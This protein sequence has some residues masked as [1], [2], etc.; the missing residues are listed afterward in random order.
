MDQF[1]VTATITNI[2]SYYVYNSQMNYVFTNM[3]TTSE[4]F[5]LYTYPGM[6]TNYTAPQKMNIELCGSQQ[7]YNKIRV[8]FNVPAQTSG[9]LVFY[10]VKS[11]NF[12][13]KYI[14]TGSKLIN[15]V[16]FNLWDK[17]LDAL[18]LMIGQGD[19]YYELSTRCL[20]TSAVCKFGI[21]TN[22]ISDCLVCKQEYELTSS[23]C[24]VCSSTV[25]NCKLYDNCICRECND[26][27]YLQGNECI[28]EVTIANCT[29]YND[30]GIFINFT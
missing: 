28:A 14:V 8:Q 18:V 9:K 3:N 4:K 15:S 19:Y 12:D 7:A 22:E 25:S 26:G 30:H 16:I 6:F 2:D 10:M 23:G 24:S 21:F 17:T 29:S 5:S 27:F 20:T 13:P 11:D 1:V